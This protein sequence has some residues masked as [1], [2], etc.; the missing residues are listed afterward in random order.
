VILT[1]SSSGPNASDLSFL[2]HKHPERV[3]EFALS[4]G[5]AL[6]FYPRYDTNACEVALVLDLDPLRL[7][8]R[9]ERAGLPLYPYVNDR[10]YVA[11]SFL[12]VAL[13][14]VFKS[15]LNGQCKTRPE[16]VN[17]AFPFELKLPCL[18]V[19]GTNLLPS[20]LFGPLGYRV[21]ATEFPLDAAFPEWGQSLGQSPYVAC[22]LASTLTLKALLNHLYVLIP[23]LDD[24]KHYWIDE[25]EVEKLLRRGETWLAKHP[26]RE[27]IVAR[28][29]KRRR[30]LVEAALSRLVA[31]EVGWE[32][33]EE[34]EERKADDAGSAP[35]H[36]QRLEAVATVL[37]ARGVARILDLGCGD[38]K[39]LALLAPDAQFTELV[40]IDASP[41]QLA[42][43]ETRLK[44]ANWRQPGRVRLLQGSLVYRDQ[45]LQGFDAVTLVEVIEHLDPPRLAT[46]E[47]VVFEF[48]A[49]RLIVVTTP[50]A[51]YNAQFAALPTEKLRHRDHRFEWRRH[52]FQQW[53]ERVARR[54]GYRFEV[55]DL[56]LA[57]PV[58]GA[59]QMAVFER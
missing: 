36:A 39:L 5:R 34:R 15:A 23:V 20:D 50:N 46:M 57:D 22:T 42:F 18:P 11:S 37:K 56:G 59:P 14:E 43:G 41:R 26:K 31:E 6:V 51:E 12:S 10:P 55:T 28:Y 29:L 8:G 53:A 2:L 1:I 25:Q 19:R 48:A 16:L 45:R 7:A 44:E 40:G 9:G 17:Y 38:C 21:S 58:H 13:A 49:P 27:L 4:F 30:P 54:F 35:L 33:R 52:E 47:R 24:E 3:Q 32:E